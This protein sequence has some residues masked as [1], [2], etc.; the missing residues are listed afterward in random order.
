M[1]H[2]LTKLFTILPLSLPT[3]SLVAAVARMMTANSART[4]A[5]FDCAAVPALG[6]VAM[7]ASK[8]IA[9]AKASAQAFVTKMVSSIVRSRIQKNVAVVHALLIFISLPIP[10]YLNKLLSRPTSILLIRLVCEYRI[11]VLNTC[12]NVLYALFVG[13]ASVRAT[14]C[15]WF[16]KGDASNLVGIRC[17]VADVVKRI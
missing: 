12:A 1:I 13:P 8:A 6:T 3:Y 14:G 11:V 5:T 15:C 16:P 4:A 17:L 2:I 7:F 9:L 10:A